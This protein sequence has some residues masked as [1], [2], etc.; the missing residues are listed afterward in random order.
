MDGNS[1]RSHI[2]SE[3]RLNA[4]QISPEAFQLLAET[5]SSDY[6]F[7]T[8]SEE[9]VLLDTTRISM[10]EG[11]QI[12]QIMRAYN[13]Q[14]SLEVG[15]ACGFS[16]IWILD[17]LLDQRAGFHQ[18]IDPS[19]KNR[20]RG[21]GLKQVERLKDANHKFR[22]LDT[23]SIHALSKLIEENE[24]FE[25]VF[26]DGNHRFDDVLVDFYLA[27]Q[28]VKTGGLVAF[29]DMW[30]PSIRTVVSFVTNNRDYELLKQPVRNMAVFKKLAPDS[31]DWRHFNW[32]EVHKQE[33]TKKKTK[34]A[35]VA[36]I[37]NIARRTHTYDL[38]RS[39]RN[40][41]H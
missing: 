27:D 6:L 16:T 30:M 7:G 33:K 24:E 18:A 20:W 36:S 34:E 13:V 23:Y 17:A 32:F 10:A 12:N 37:A 26:V 5:Y 19:E 31:R 29:D 22:W 41:S 11:S 35:I 3:L 9:P 4:P 39:F 8:E 28:V 21:V 38:L 40:L 25:F 2:E 14:R 1:R 15:F